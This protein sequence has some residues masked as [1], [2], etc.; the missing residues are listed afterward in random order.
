[1][2]TTADKL[3][4]IINVIIA[5]TITSVKPYLE[6]VRFKNQSHLADAVVSLLFSSEADKEGPLPFSAAWLIP[7]SLPA[8]EFLP[9]PVSNQGSQPTISFAGIIHFTRKT[10][11][12]S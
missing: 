9:P 6:K 3:Q 11:Y 5:H 12:L 1:L 4:L 8:A 2:A 10:N 7:L